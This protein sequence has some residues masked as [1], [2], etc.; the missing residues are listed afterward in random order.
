MLH[1]TV[2]FGLKPN[3]SDFLPTSGED[4][5]EPFLKNL[6]KRLWGTGFLSKAALSAE[7]EKEK[8]PPG[9]QRPVLHAT[10][11]EI[12][13]PGNIVHT[14]SPLMSGWSGIG[15][16]VRPSHHHDSSGAEKPSG[17]SKPSS[18]QPL[19]AL[20][21]KH[22]RHRKAFS[23]KQPQSSSLPSHRLADDHPV[24]RSDDGP[25]ACHQYLPGPV[26]RR[27]PTT[28]V[29]SGRTWPIQKC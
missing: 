28:E 6:N 29:F 13:A 9:A 11:R 10:I 5:P 26:E 14:R 27:V 20:G 4:A 2:C 7:I 1:G 17:Y 25:A 8:L 3:V 22:R 18:K 24:S 15:D 12:G 19:P 21:H 16:V 23:K